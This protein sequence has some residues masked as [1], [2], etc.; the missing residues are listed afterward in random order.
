MPPILTVVIP[1]LGTRPSFLEEAIRSI[2]P[3]K[4][5]VR[6]V[7][8]GPRT[9]LKSLQ[10]E[11]PVELLD[12]PGGGP[13]AAI[14]F[15]MRTA[16][17]DYVTW[18]GD[19][20]LLAGHRVADGCS[21]LESVP[22]AP[23]LFGD[24]WL[25]DSAG[26]P[27]SLMRPGPLAEHL[28]R[29]GPD[30]LPQ[31]GSILRRTAVEEVGFLNTELSY[32]FDLDLFLRLRK[33]GKPLRVR[34]PLACFRLHPESLTVSNPRPGVEARQVRRSAGSSLL[35]LT[36]PALYPVVKAATRLLAKYQWHVP[37]QSAF[38]SGR[39]SFLPSTRP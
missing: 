4:D 21:R 33:I 11:F 24:C 39:H 20:D 16:S 26:R 7:V 3:A 14:N 23:Y 8:V 25:I 22:S 1:T 37:N 9:N 13:A 38:T 34:V 18:L 19:D 12:D 10:N 36:E 31:P 27:I 2:L 29:I 28:L 6:I 15:A 35:R 5:L 32:A 17:S 30:R